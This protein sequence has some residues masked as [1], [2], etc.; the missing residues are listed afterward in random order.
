MGPDGMKMHKKF[1]LAPAS[2]PLLRPHLAA[3]VAAVATAGCGE[4]SAGSASLLSRATA[5]T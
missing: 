3:S 1:H 2:L 5:R 4:Q